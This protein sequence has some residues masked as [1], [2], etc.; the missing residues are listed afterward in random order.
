MGD[1]SSFCWLLVSWKD[2]YC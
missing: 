2:D 1:I